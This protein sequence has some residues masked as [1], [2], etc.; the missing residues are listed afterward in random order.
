MVAPATIHSDASVVA[1]KNGPHPSWKGQGPSGLACRGLVTD[2]LQNKL[3][4][5]IPVP[6]PEQFGRGARTS[7]P[8]H[9]CE[10]TSVIP[11]HFAAPASKDA[12]RLAPGGIQHDHDQKGPDGA[13]WAGYVIVFSGFVARAFDRINAIHRC[14]PNAISRQ[15]APMDEP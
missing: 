7:E 4:S 12:D 15:K 1:L 10:A 5:P 2:R 8:P 13:P 11:N 9:Q 6:R 3:R 14:T